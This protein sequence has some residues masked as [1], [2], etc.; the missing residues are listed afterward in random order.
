MRETSFKAK[1]A[2]KRLS[3]VR[4]KQSEA[5]SAS[6]ADQKLRDIKSAPYQH[7]R[8]ETPLA[9]KGSFMGKSELGATATSKSLCRTLLETKQPFS[10]DFLFH[11]DL[12]EEDCE[13]VRNKNE[14]RVVRGILPLLVPSTE[15]SDDNSSHSLPTRL[16]SV[17]ALLRRYSP[18]PQPLLRLLSDVPA[19][20]SSDQS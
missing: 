11:D 19:L 2:R 10:D 15:V 17:A 18:S 9:I 3:S 7:A 6:S 8:Y 4:G 12:F 20:P 5:S 1:F 14:A 13:M 16:V